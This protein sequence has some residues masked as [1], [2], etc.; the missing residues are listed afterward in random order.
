M[1]FSALV[2]LAWMVAVLAFAPEAFSED[3]EFYI[4]TRRTVAETTTPGVRARSMGGSYVA[5]ANGAESV[6]ENPAGLGALTGKSLAGGVSFDWL[7]DGADNTTRT[8]VVGGGAMSLEKWLPEGGCNQSLGIMY[9]GNS[10]TGAGGVNMDD[11]QGQL[12]FAYGAHLLEDFLVG[13]A[14]TIFDGDWT[15][16]DAY[17]PYDRKYTGGEFRL[18][19]IYRA[20]DSL[21]V[22]GTLSYAAGSYRNNQ[23]MNYYSYTPHSSGDLRRW[24][25]R[26]GVGYQLCDDTLLAGDVAYSWLKTDLPGLA[27]E[28]QSDW[29]FSGGIE[30]QVLP[31]LL[32]LRGG[33]YYRTSSFSATGSY[34]HTLPSVSTSYWGFT[35]GAGLRVR[36]IDLGYSLDVNTQGDI[37]NLLSISSDW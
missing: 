19:G 11:K 25:A 35:A 15:A 3:Q 22:G 28:K 5:L 9:R 18:G 23:T 16:N 10:T 1:R 14:V 33:L 29:T 6:G 17:S 24:N 2:L 34:L 8:T 7:D 31:D 30:N 36:S 21:T 20:A 37:G 13:A 32:A 26:G 27:N 12:T 4:R